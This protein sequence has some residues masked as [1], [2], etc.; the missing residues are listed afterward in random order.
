MPKTGVSY[1][2]GQAKADLVA[3]MRKAF[4]KVKVRQLEASDR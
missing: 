1:P 3:R 4:S 2:K